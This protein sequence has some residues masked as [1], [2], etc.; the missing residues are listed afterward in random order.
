MKILLLIISIVLPVSLLSCNN[1]VNY[2]VPD[3]SPKEFTT[4]IKGQVLIG[5]V[6]PIERNG[7]INKTPFEAALK[8]V[9]SDENVVEKIRTDENGKFKLEL[10]PGA[11]TIIPE[12]IINTG[13]YPLGKNKNITV[14][15]GEIVFVEVDFDSGIR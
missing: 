8:F 5:P 13:F 2:F 3:S 6:S 14:K 12:P 9:D 1:I 7:I 15:S 10:K 4:G 11:Y